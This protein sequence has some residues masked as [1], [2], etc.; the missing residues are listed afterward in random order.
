MFSV[1]TYSLPKAGIKIQSGGHTKHGLAIEIMNEDDP[2]SLQ[3]DKT[4]NRRYALYVL[5]LV[6]SYAS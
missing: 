2:S 4:R 5:V 1:E 6:Q 3:L